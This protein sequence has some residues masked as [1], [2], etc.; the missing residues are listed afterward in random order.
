VFRESYLTKEEPDRLI[1][2]I[3]TDSDKT[4][5]AAIMVMLLTGARKR[6]VTHA[7]WENIDLEWKRLKVPVSKNGHAR[8]IVLSPPVIE[9]LKNMPRKLIMHGCFRLA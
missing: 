1:A 4:A 3:E 9:L 2:A 8:H 7:R 6:E 5:A